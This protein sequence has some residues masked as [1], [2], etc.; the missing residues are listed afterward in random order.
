VTESDAAILHGEVAALQA[1][2]ISI[3][4]KLSA[5][6]PDMTQDFC[7][8]FDEAETI[9]TGLAVRLGSEPSS[10]TTI[11]ALRVLEEIRGGVLERGVCS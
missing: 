7:S 4:R 2:L 3:L 9:L 1:V 5:E 11:T 8:A 10:L 6:R